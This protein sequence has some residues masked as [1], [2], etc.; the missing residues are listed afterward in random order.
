[1]PY[2]KANRKLFFLILLIARWHIL[3]YRGISF[4]PM[5]VKK[6]VKP[7]KSSILLL[8]VFNTLSGFPAF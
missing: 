6:V 8:D 3:A 2:F 5:V 4:L 1:M 7:K